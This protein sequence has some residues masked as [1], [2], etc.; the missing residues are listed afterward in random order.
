M[1][2]SLIAGALAACRQGDEARLAGLLEEL[3]YGDGRR[4]ATNLVLIHRHLNAETLL[5][6]LLRDALATACPDDALNF[7]ERLGNTADPADLSKV[8]QS[9]ASRRQLL[10]ILG[11]SPFLAG[12]LCRDAHYLRRLLVEGDLLRV[13]QGAEMAVELRALI[14]DEVDFAGLQQGLRRYKRREILRIG[15]R[16]LCGLA[17]LVETT[18]ALSDLAGA[19]LH[20]AYEVCDLLLRKEYGTPR[21]EGE[22]GE[23]PEFT[24]LGMGKFGGRELNFSSDIDLI[25][26]YSSERG[27]TAGIADGRGGAR[28]RIGLHQYFVKLAEMLTRALGQA[29]VDGFVFRVDL[30]LRPDGS[31]GEMAMSRRGAEV[32]YESWGQSWERA[33]LLKARP[34][35]GSL[36]L[37][38]RLLKELDPFIYRRYLDYGMVEDIKTMKMKIDHNLARQREGE[39]NLKLGRGGIREIEFF[40]QALQLIYA[41]KN[42]LLRERNTLKA[43]DLLCREGLIREEDHRHLRDAYVFLR[44][45]E[46]RIQVVQE[47]QTHNLP[48]KDSEL[49]LLARR[50]GFADLPSFLQALENHRLGVQAIY[51]DLFFSGEEKIR[52]E[53]RPEIA[54]LFD[55]AA[56]PDLVKDM[57][58]ERGFKNVEGAYDNL[59]LLRDGGSHTHLTERSRRLLERIAPLLLQEVIDTPEPDM[60]LNSLVRFLGALRARSTFYALLAENREI[61][62]LLVNLFGTSQFLSRI[63]IQ[64]PEILDALVS[65]Q[66]VVIRKG[67]ERLRAD[68]REQLARSEDYEAKL[69]ALRR[70]RSEEFLRI[71]LHD[72]SGELSL[73]EG[74]QQLSLLA[75]VC[76]EQ[77][78][79]IARAELLPRFGIPLFTDEAGL[80]R[81]AA[82]AIVGMGKLGGHELTY[83]SDLDIIFIYEADGH[84]A[85][86]PDGD[87]ERFRE[88]T[89]Q[90]YFSRL[91]QRVISVLTLQTREGHV[92]KIDTRL[93]PS[94]NQGPL[95]SSL[96]AF[97]RYH[98]AS[99]ALWERQALT[100]ARVVT[101]P[102]EFARRVEEICAHQVYGRPVPAQLKDEIY[103]LRGRMEAEIAR[104]SAEHFNIKTGRGG[105]VDVEFLAQY[106]QL[107]HGGANPELR[108]ASTTQL[109]GALSRA[110]ILDASELQALGSGYVFLRRLENKLRLVH[111]QSINDLSGERNYLVKLARRL[112]YPERPVRPDQAFLADYRRVTD[113]IRA[114]FERHLG[115]GARAGAS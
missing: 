21:L 55:A 17:D 63:F 85:P 64:H 97:E 108:T 27:E 46:H 6:D 3:G 88:L 83:H 102:P 34:V 24:V 115:P 111:D 65:R 69:D 93:R 18:A 79:E 5:V 26:V 53:V 71:A 36:A 39:L 109:L 104:E 38:E 107:L 75:D 98:Q 4:G 61:I 51:R 28:N 99:A 113:G 22:E 58:E 56:E 66:N 106:L 1:T 15:G 68:L 33:A 82:F 52:E 42:P 112:G 41:G 67:K 103:R 20:R 32:Y 44:T 60:A 62:R 90:E 100:K 78:V 76:L 110:K 72:L 81:E 87:P 114:I 43:L 29:T 84:N 9:A 86:A 91:A 50:S 101:G 89:N 14:A 105:M 8:L 74:T 94:G 47:R 30:N 37:G 77:A 48:K 59:L 92:Y 73:A 12:I 49:L 16:D 13:K 7:L 96:P 23:E 19:C 2:D 80:T 70:F 10:R 25:Y 45:V 11:A 57:L 95:V 35:A 54:F 31:R 40:I